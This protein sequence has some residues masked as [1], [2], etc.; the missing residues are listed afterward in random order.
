VVWIDL[1]QDRVQP[2]SSAVLKA[3]K[4]KSNGNETFALH[5]KDVFRK[6]PWDGLLG[7]GIGLLGIG[8]NY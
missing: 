4:I 2:A 5:N 8:M 3:L 6:W 7:I 1:A